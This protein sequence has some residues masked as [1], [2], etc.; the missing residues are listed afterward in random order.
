M[1]G[2]AKGDRGGLVYRGPRFRD[3]PAVDLDFAGQDE[4]T[5]A[6]A[7]LGKAAS[8]S[9]ASS[10]D[11]GIKTSCL[12]TCRYGGSEEALCRYVGYRRVRGT[13]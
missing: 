4:R 2:H 6:L 7:G 9:N 8:T 1:I 5:R 11:L 12:K 13:F 3:R 10:R